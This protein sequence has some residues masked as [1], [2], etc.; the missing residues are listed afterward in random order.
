MHISLNANEVLRMSLGPLALVLKKI[1]FLFT[2]MYEILNKVVGF[3][4]EVILGVG[5]KHIKPRGTFG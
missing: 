4:W 1:N 2:E 3:C 5:P